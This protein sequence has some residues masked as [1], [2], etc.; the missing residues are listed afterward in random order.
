MAAQ[1]RTSPHKIGSCI[2]INLLVDPL[3][4]ADNR[5]L[6]QRC[7]V[8]APGADAHPRNESIPCGNAQ[9]GNAAQE[10]I[11]PAR[12]VAASWSR[13]LAP[14]ASRQS[15]I[16]WCWEVVT[17]PRSSEPP[18]SPQPK[19]HIQEFVV[20][21]SDGNKAVFQWPSS[22]NQA[23]ADDITDSLKIVQH[24]ILRAVETTDVILLQCQCAAC[25]NKVHRAAPGRC[26][27]KTNATGP[28]NLHKRY[29]AESSHLAR[30]HTNAPLPRV[31]PD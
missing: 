26:T 30:T 11:V 15:R 25:S 9:R 17:S 1:D 12:Q 22:L 16:R 14:G 5:D 28:I 6:R 8:G 24:K 27:A 4:H 7:C 18:M 19:T 13:I 21:L 20:P 23:D 31:F 3:Q 2:P 29:R 10:S